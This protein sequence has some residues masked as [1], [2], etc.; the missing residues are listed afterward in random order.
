MEKTNIL[1]KEP[2]KS[3][4]ILLKKARKKYF[5]YHLAINLYRLKK[6]LEKSYQNTLHCSSILYQEGNKIITKYCKNRW[7]LVCNSIRTAKLINGYLPSI[8]EFLTP[9]FVTLTVPTCASDKL[10][11]RIKKMQEVWAKLINISKYYKIGLKGIKKAECTVRPD[12]Q[13]HYHF[14][15]ILEGQEQAKWLIT[16]WLKYTK[17]MGSR[18]PA[19]DMRPLKNLVGGA[20]ELFKYFTKILVKDK[21]TGKSYVDYNGLD[22]IFTAL[23][24]QRIYS[25][26]GGIKSIPEEV[27]NITSQDIKDSDKIFWIYQ[28]SLYDWIDE[29]TGELLTGYIPTNS[30]KQLLNNK[31][32]SK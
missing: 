7:C 31:K 22:I 30:F 19:Q 18:K 13:F 10:S 2:R 17:E 25:T 11:R 27:A 14:H 24:K 32:T 5:S 20:L 3:T 12:G 28:S 26:F 21:T 8:N 15:I 16:N 6:P 23:Q 9:Y 4:N 29:N 1:V